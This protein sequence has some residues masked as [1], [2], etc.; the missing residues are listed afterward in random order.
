MSSPSTHHYYHQHHHHY[1][2][3]LKHW[4]Q[5]LNYHPLSIWSTANNLFIKLHNDHLNIDQKQPQSLSMAIPTPT[6]A[7][8][9]PIF[10]ED[11]YYNHSS[12]TATRTES[13]AT[14]ESSSSLSSSSLSLVAILTLDTILTLILPYSIIFILSIVGNLLVIITLTLDRSMRSVTN[15]FLLNLAISD[16][17]LGVFCMPFTLVGVLLRRFIFGAFVCHMISYFQAVSVAVSVWTLVSMSIERYYAICHPFRSRESRQ[18]KKHAYRILAMVW[19]LA[20]ITMSPTAIVS[21]LQQT[22]QTGHY[23]CR[24]AWPSFLH[25]QVF[26]LFLDFILLIIPLIIMIMTYS[27]IALTLRNSVSVKKQQTQTN[28]DNHNHQQQKQ[29]GQTKHLQMSIAMTTMKNKSSS[30]SYKTTSI[31]QQQD[32][33]SLTDLIDADNTSNNIRCQKFQSNQNGNHMSDNNHS[34]DKRQS[35]RFEIDQNIAE[36]VISPTTAALLLNRSSSNHRV[37]SPIINNGLSSSLEHCGSGSSV[38]FANNRAILLVANT[39]SH[40][41]HGTSRQ[42]RIIIM[43][44]V[45]VIEFFICWSPIFLLDTM[46]LYRP[47]L[48]Y[49]TSQ[50]VSRWIGIDIISVCHLLCFCSTC[51]NPITY[52][53]MN[54]RF[55][56]HFFSLFRCRAAMP[57]NIN[58]PSSIQQPNE[59]KA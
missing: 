3:H 49:G 9:M 8:I 58:N 17:L 35:N 43:L 15:I 6:T 14:T 53:F 21:K 52:C 54:K 23:K 12:S 31:H 46:A 45:V 56:D 48:V 24:E 42:R 20:F 51:N 27:S 39:S 10:Y 36:T 11:D 44:F 30:Y 26:T 18:T 22:N 59:I 5:D 57:V 25:K 1:H 4:P 7:T 47:E 34:Y 37:Q 32:N 19:T 16:L 33:C 2:T 40:S 28:G 13:L 38:Q 29:L 50:K 55:R 41:Y